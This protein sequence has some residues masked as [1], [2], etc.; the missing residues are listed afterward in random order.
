MSNQE[1]QFVWAEGWE[2]TSRDGTKFR[3]SGRSNMPGS[4]PVVLVDESA[5]LQRYFTE[6]GRWARHDVDHDYDIFSARR[7][8]QEQSEVPRW[9][10]DVLDHLKQLVENRR[11]DSGAVIPLVEYIEARPVRMVAEREAYQVAINIIEAAIAR[12]AATAATPQAASGKWPRYAVHKND[13]ENRPTT[14]ECY[15]TFAKQEASNVDW[16]DSR[17]PRGRWSSRN[18]ESLLADGTWVETDAEGNELV[19]PDL[20]TL[21]ASEQAIAEGRARPLQEVVDELKAS[22]P[23]QRDVIFSELIF[24]L[25]SGLASVATRAGAER[26]NKAV[27]AIEAHVAERD[28]EI[29]ELRELKIRM[30]RAIEF[31]SND[32]NT[33]RDGAKLTRDGLVMMV[34]YGNEEIAAL[35]TEA[36]RIDSEHQRAISS[37]RQR[38]E[39]AEAKVARLR[40]PIATEFDFDEAANKAAAVIRDRLSGP[41]GISLDWISDAISAKIRPGVEELYRKLQHRRCDTCGANTIDGCMRC[42]APQC[43]PQCCKID[44]LTRELEAANLALGDR[45]KLIEEI[46]AVTYGREASPFYANMVL[47]MRIEALCGL[48][49]DAVD[50]LTIA[51]LLLGQCGATF[52]IVG[53]FELRLK[54]GGWKIYRP[55]TEKYL[56]DC[57]GQTVWPDVF[58]AYQRA[59]ELADVGKGGAA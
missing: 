43:C 41:E 30:D 52:F 49:G 50:Q 18:G 56:V 8:E 25:R 34:A 15:T 37:L 5:K 22:E 51:K 57:N 1:Q 9:A 40:T 3:F 24:E 47:V 45:K 58:T 54:E 42:G 39:A 46:E 53:P 31:D 20:V 36:D 44:D 4:H 21:K 55:A 26:A 17:S 7:I 38:A 28:A 6:D 27:A 2:Y 33:M 29:A 13:I 35:R 32:L 11:R 48:R 12:H 16:I 14:I 19:Q 23:T 10:V 59:K